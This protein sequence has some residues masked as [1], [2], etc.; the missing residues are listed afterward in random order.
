M[1]HKGVIAN[2]KRP[3]RDLD[4]MHEVLCLN[5][6]EVV[7]PDDVVYLLGDVCWHHRYLQLFNYLNGTIHLLLGNHDHEKV[8]KASRWESVRDLYRLKHNEW[9]LMLSHYP[10]ESWNGRERGSI[11]LHGHTHNNMSHKVQILP[12]RYDVGVDCWSFYPVHID[13]ILEK[14]KN[15]DYQI[16]V[17]HLQDEASANR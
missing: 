7:M 9:R 2:C 12:R 4:H 17:S 10:Q 11:H 15:D 13:I 1:G 3:F 14:A 6:N 5:W 8:M 16:A